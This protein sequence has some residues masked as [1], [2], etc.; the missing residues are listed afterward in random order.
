MTE[1]HY[2][3]GTP[4]IAQPQTGKAEFTGALLQA[5]LTTRKVQALCALAWDGPQTWSYTVSLGLGEDP[6]KVER[7]AGALALAAGSDHCRV[8]RDAGRLLLEVAKPAAERQTLRADRLDVLKPPT[9]YAVPVGVGTGGR[10]V[11]LDLGDERNAHVLIGGT[12]GSGKTELLRWLLYRLARQN[13]PERLRLLLLDPKRRELQ[14]FANL[15]HLLNPTVSNP[16]DCARVLAWAVAELDR[17][18]ESGRTRPRVVIVVE[19]VAD[20]ATTAGILPAL[21]RIAQVGRGLGMNLIATTQQPGA[22]SL[23][24]SLANYPCRLLGRV[25]SSTLTFGAAGR[26]RT[27]A[28]GLLGRGDF[29]MLSAGEAVRFQAPLMS[30]E[31]WAKL[32]TGEP[33]DLSEQLPTL[34][35]FGDLQRDPR[36]GHHRRDLA[37]ADYTAIEDALESGMTVDELRDQFGIGYTRARRIADQLR[38]ET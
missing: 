17:R 21:S 25:A 29:I 36:G 6:E 32:P 3:T 2:M 34:A 23:G 15:P 18:A 26:A 13:P 37:P 38:G 9:G 28:D 27:G 24:D 14:P 30:G 22:R 33:G 20:L 1:A 12:T 4:P 31:L 10:V 19:E 5:T 11:W 8:A 7:L 35:Q 16:L